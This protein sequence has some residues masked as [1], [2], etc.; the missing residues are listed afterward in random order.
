MDQ[1]FKLHPI[2]L[3]FKFH[4]YFEQVFYACDIMM[5]YNYITEMKKYMSNLLQRLYKH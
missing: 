2:N 4:K 5:R 3:G 1:T